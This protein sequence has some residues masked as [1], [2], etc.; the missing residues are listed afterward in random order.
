MPSRELYFQQ[1]F[2]PT[3]STYSYLLAD[4][5]TKEAVLIDSVLEMHD[6]DLKLIRELGLKLLYTLDTHI[7]ADHITG[8]GKIAD[9]TGAHICISAAAGCTGAQLALKD[10]DLIK[11]GRFEICAIATPGHTPSCMCY[12]VSDRVFTGDTLLIRGSGRTDFQNGSAADLYRNITTKLFSLPETTLVFPGHDYN[13]FT[14]SSI[15]M[16]KKLNPRIGG[17]RTLEQFVQIMQDLHLAPPK[18]IEVAIPANLVC[19]R[20]S[21]EQA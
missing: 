7:H 15:A 3:T 13:G 14:S 5:E 4:A 19:G 10:G 16:E 20:L 8:A 2:E 6:R 1:L 17:G 18:N 9:V 21:K 12:F 11:F